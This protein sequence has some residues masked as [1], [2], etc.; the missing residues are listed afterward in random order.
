VRCYQRLFDLTEQV[1][2]GRAV[3]PLHDVPQVAAL[4]AQKEVGSWR[5]KERVHVLNIRTVTFGTLVSGGHQDSP[6]RKFWRA[7][8]ITVRRFQKKEWSLHPKLVA[9]K[10]VENG[11]G[12]APCV[13]IRAWFDAL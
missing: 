7:H 8:H 6:L 13:E 3:L 9:Y 1:V 11:L 12:R 5:K 2:H 4:G 10:V